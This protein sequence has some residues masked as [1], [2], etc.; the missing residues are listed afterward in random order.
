M[1]EAC[2]GAEE[3][4]QLEHYRTKLPVWPV[5]RFYVED[6]GFLFDNTLLC[7]LCVCISLRFRLFSVVIIFS[8]DCFINSVLAYF[9]ISHIHCLIINLNW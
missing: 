1:C 4:R 3:S 9:H 8:L 6:F 7:C 5:E 2:T